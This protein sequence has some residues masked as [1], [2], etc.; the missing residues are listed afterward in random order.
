MPSDGP[1][2][3]ELPRGNFIGLVNYHNMRLVLDMGNN[4]P[5]KGQVGKHLILPPGYT[6]SIPE[7]YWKAI[8]F[9]RSLSP[10]G[11]ITKALQA[12]DTIKVYPLSKAEEQ[13]TFHFVDVKNETLINPLLEW[14][15][16][17]DYWQ[18]LKGVNDNE[19]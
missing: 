12:L 18:Q 7:A 15:G 2:V 14:E 16:K 1:M 6:G 9:I 17:L 3:V 13:V 19:T 4:G 10:E 8:L 5:D 11:N